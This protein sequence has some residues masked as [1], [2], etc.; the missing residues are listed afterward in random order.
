MPSKNLDVERLRSTVKRNELQV[1]L[2]VGPEPPKDDSSIES[3]A[4]KLFTK[5]YECSEQILDHPRGRH[6]DWFDDNGI[7]IGLTTMR[8]KF[9]ACYRNETW[10]AKH[11]CQGEVETSTEN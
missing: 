9:I 10:H 5:V 7:K 4:K 2:H 6:K 1:A 3:K 11:Y 8:K